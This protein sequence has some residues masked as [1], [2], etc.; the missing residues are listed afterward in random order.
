M[1]SP[2]IKV[3][4]ISARTGEGLGDWYHWLREQ[5]QAAREAVLV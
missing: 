3:L 2:E 4:T 5:H 1:V